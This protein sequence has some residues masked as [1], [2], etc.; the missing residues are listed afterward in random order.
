MSVEQEVTLD[1]IP[2][3][4]KAAIEKKAAGGKIIKVETI[5]KGNT[6]TYEAA[7]QKGSRKS[8]VTVAADG[9]VVN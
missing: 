4:A 9:S 3:G 6:V 2:A 7:L 8:E 5:T 1:S